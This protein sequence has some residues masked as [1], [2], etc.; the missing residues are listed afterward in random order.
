VKG[1]NAVGASSSEGNS[2]LLRSYF[3]FYNFFMAP[4][5]TECVEMPLSV[6]TQSRYLQLVGTGRRPGSRWS[7]RRGWS[8]K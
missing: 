7:R 5:A 3:L 8:G 1:E 2:S 4:N 6:I